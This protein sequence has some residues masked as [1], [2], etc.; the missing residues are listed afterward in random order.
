MVGSSLAAALY[1][2]DKWGAG[3]SSVRAHNISNYFFFPSNSITP[4]TTLVKVRSFVFKTIDWLS[5][6]YKFCCATNVVS[7]N[8]LNSLLL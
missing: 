7:L 2:Y 1:H 3:I 5:G 6:L 8:L 4:E